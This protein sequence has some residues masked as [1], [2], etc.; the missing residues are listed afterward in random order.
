M[1]CVDLQEAKIRVSEGIM[2]QSYAK[3]NLMI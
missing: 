1:E 2:N 3:A